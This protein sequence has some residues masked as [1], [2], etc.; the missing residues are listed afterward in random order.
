M[1]NSTSTI[2]TRDVARL[3]KRSTATINR[4]AQ[5]GRLPVLAKA[6][7]PRGAYLFDRAAIERIAAEAASC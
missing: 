4:A 5:S 2:A 6:P 7:G 1:D 3:L